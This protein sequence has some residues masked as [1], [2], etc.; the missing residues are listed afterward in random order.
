MNHITQEGVGNKVPQQTQPATSETVGSTAP[1]PKRTSDGRSTRWSH[2]REERKAQILDVARTLIH[3]EG[4]AVTMD[5]IAHASGTS[6]SILYRYF[7]DKSELQ[8]ALGLHLF[9]AMHRELAA[10]AAPPASQ[11]PRP[12]AEAMHGMV[13]AF[14]TAAHRSRNLFDF[15]TQPSPGLGLFLASVRRL[16]ASILPD[17]MPPLEKRLFSAGAVSLVHSVTEQWIRST[18]D[19]PL[20]ELTVDDITA[21]IVRWLTESPLPPLD[22]SEETS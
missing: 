9:N 13:H 19:D 6:K 18:P 12:T 3:A 5:R 1:A 22:T 20:S 2:H 14:V 4:P 10:Q 11:S 7:R 16:V 8:R 17:T 15:V 21:M